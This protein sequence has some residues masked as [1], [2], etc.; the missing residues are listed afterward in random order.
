MNTVP[1]MRDRL[2]AAMTE[3][4]NPGQ[5]AMFRLLVEIDPT[6]NLTDEQLGAFARELAAA[7]RQVTR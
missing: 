1:T 2:A 5:W 7:Y 6:P 3:H 4:A